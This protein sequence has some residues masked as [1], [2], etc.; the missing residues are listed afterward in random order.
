VSIKDKYRVLPIKK[1]EI[2]EWLLYKHYAKRIPNIMYLFGLYDGVLLVGVISFGSSANSSYGNDFIELNRLVVNDGLEKNALSFFVSSALKCLPVPI[3]IVSYSDLK[4]N[5][6]GYIYQATNWIYT[7][8]SSIDTSW[9]KGNHIYHRK[10]L[11]DKYGESGIEFLKSKGYE[12]IREMPKHRYFYV[13]EK[14]KKKTLKMKQDIIS[15]FGIKPYPKGDNKKYNANY[16][17]A[18]QKRLF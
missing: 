15:R 3:A 1:E 17:P 5:H 14:T 9:A 2:Y 13:K 7:G 18:T 10:S 11:Y 16:K 6:H 4:M 8:M 12:M